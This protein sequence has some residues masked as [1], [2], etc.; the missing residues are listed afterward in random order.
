MD[1]RNQARN[2]N[3]QL[4]RRVGLT[5]SSPRVSA[6]TTSSRRCRPLRPGRSRSIDGRPLTRRLRRDRGR[7]RISPLRPRL[8]HG[9]LARRSRN[10]IGAPSTTSW[11]VAPRPLVDT[12]SAATS[13]QGAGLSAPS[14]ACSLVPGAPVSRAKL[15]SPASCCTRQL[16]FQGVCFQA[17]VDVQRLGRHAGD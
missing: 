17:C 7:G 8:P 15:P 13:A 14:F 9:P 4:S 11:P 3:V 2:Q 10:R 16:S 5:T 1:C 6:D 12:S